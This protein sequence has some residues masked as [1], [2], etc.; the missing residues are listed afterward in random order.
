MIEPC[1][2]YSW[3]HEK[4]Y[5]FVYVNTIRFNGPTSA[6]MK[7]ARRHGLHGADASTYFLYIL[8]VEMYHFMDVT[9]G[10]ATAV[11]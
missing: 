1:L 7:V 9:T 8:V 3:K 6:S 4:L 10:E 11:N 2:Q 5:E